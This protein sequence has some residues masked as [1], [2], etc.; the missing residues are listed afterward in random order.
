MSDRVEY[1]KEYNR[2]QK[3]E[4][5]STDIK[6]TSTH[7][8]IFESERE[9]TNDHKG[10]ILDIEVENINDIYKY[11]FSLFFHN[12]IV[13]TSKTEPPVGFVYYIYLD[14]DVIRALVYSK[15]L[16]TDRYLTIQSMDTKVL[17]L[18]LKH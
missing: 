6:K 15:E 2:K 11:D 1:K 4:K 14:G 17:S 18:Y 12:P 7:K 8:I 16:L 5:M 10:T 3:G 13:I 9:Y